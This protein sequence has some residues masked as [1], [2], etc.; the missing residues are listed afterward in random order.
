MISPY[1]YRS[2]IWLFNLSLCPN[3][4]KLRQCIIPSRSTVNCKSHLLIFFALSICYLSL[5]I[6][7]IQSGDVEINPGLIQRVIRDSFHQGDQRFGQT[8]GTQCMCIAL[9]SVG[10][11]IIKK[12]CYWSTWDMDNILTA[13]NSLHSSLA[14]RLQLFKCLWIAQFNLYREDSDKYY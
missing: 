8:S 14:F 6:L 3:F 7:L 10:Y 1:A 2:T 12:V 13:G 9:Y 4:S 5:M 11:S